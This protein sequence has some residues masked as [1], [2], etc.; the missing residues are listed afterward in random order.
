MHIKQE[1]SRNQSLSVL[2]LSQNYLKLLSREIEDMETT[3]EAIRTTEEVAEEDITKD[4]KEVQTTHQQW[5]GV[6]MTHF[7]TNNL[8]RKKILMESH[9]GKDHQNS[10]ARRQPS[11]I[12]KT[13][14]LN[15]I[16]IRTL[17]L[18]RAAKFCCTKQSWLLN[19]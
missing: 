8:K 2:K 15:V 11:P 5:T 19:L 3:E 4:L 7:G 10:S 9:L 14:A 13:F 18:K 1:D 6:H 16:Q 12:N 17:Q